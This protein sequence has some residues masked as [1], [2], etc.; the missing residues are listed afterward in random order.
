[1]TS[2]KTLTSYIKRYNITISIKSEK[3]DL[4]ISNNSSIALSYRASFTCEELYKLNRFFRQFDNVKEIY[5]FIANLENIEEKISIKQED[6]FINLKISLPI[7]FKHQ[8]NTEITFVLPVVEIK[9]S[10]LII[11]LCKEVEKINVLENKINFLFDCFGKTEKD[12]IFYEETMNKI[13]K[14]LKKIESTIIIPVD[15]ATVQ[16]GIKQKLNKKIKEAK[17]L[18]RASRDGD[19]D[20]YHSKCDGKENTVTFI[21]AKNGR[22]FGGFVS[23]AFHYNDG[24]INDPNCFVFSLFY[25][26]CYYKN[27]NDQYGYN[28]SHPGPEWGGGHDLTLVNGCLSNT[29]SYCKQS[30]YNYNGKSNAL[31]GGGNFQVEDYETYELI[32]E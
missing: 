24:W 25:K 10:E 17:L 32:L 12:F 31:C 19:S 5:E 30:S 15:F 27:N 4:N 22:K 26:E 2:I 9:E 11:K 14:N 13:V 16:T 6:K 7:I 1:M 20:K 18:Y 21:K 29:N 3:L 23:K 8:R 28:G